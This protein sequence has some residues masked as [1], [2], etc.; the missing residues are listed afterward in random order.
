MNEWWN[1]DEVSCLEEVHHHCQG[2]ISNG[3]TEKQ[4]TNANRKMNTNT[5]DTK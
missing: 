3:T 4:T 1:N 2:Y 5:N